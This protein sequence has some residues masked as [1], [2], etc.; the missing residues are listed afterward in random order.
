[1]HFSKH[2]QIKNSFIF[3][4]LNPFKTISYFYDYFIIV[5]DISTLKNSNKKLFVKFVIFVWMYF[6]LHN[7]YLYLFQSYQTDFKHVIHGDLIFYIFVL[8]NFYLVFTIAGSV[9]FY[10]LY[11]FY[12]NAEMPV[13]DMYRF[14]ILGG[15]RRS[16]LYRNVPQTLMQKFGPLKTNYRNIEIVY[17]IRICAMIMANVMQVFHLT[18]GNI[19]I[20]CYYYFLNIYFSEI[21][22]L[23]F[24]SMMLRKLC[25]Y[26]STLFSY[27]YFQIT[28][29][30]L[31]HFVNC[32]FYNIILLSFSHVLI[33]LSTLG[34]MA[35]LY[36][37]IRVTQNLKFLH[38]TLFDFHW[39]KIHQFIISDIQ[40]FNI[41]LKINPSFS[42]L[43]L[44]FISTNLP[45]SALIL[46]MIIQKQVHGVTLLYV[47][48]FAGSQFSC[49]LVM[50]IIFAIFSKKLHSSAR[51]LKNI[52]VLNQHRVGQF[53]IRL[54][55][56]LTVMRLSVNK[57]YG[58][59]YG[60]IGLVTLAAFFKSVLL[61]FEMMMYFYKLMYNY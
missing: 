54:R 13:I 2:F 28:C 60:S 25:I 4:V 6:L 26:S 14:V 11:K 37:N 52:T 51:L 30:L 33:L 48:S 20:F 40:T 24:H 43:F 27:S 57:K 34:M 58:I 17:F 36:G 61:Y 19:N 22:L 23:H 21:I 5:E 1:M 38:T 32:F 53:R 55:L 47:S 41:F 39:G 29:L 49:I 42:N 59:Q 7:F 3:K 9:M 50:H 46:L 18:M 16:F 31:F 35:I 10:P 45:T 56:S 44:A 15:K 8:P 12:L